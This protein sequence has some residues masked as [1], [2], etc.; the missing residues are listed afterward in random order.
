MSLVRTLSLSLGTFGIHI[1]KTSLSVQTSIPARL[2]GTAPPEAAA[3]APDQWQTRLRLRMPKYRPRHLLATNS[4]STYCNEVWTQSRNQRDLTMDMDVQA[5]PCFSPLLLLQYLA[6]SYCFLLVNLW[7]PN[8]P[9]YYSSFITVTLW[10][11]NLKCAMTSLTPHSTELFAVYDVFHLQVCSHTKAFQRLWMSA[12][13]LSFTYPNFNFCYVN[14]AAS[15]AVQLK[16]FHSLGLIQS[17][18]KFKWLDPSVLVAFGAEHGL[19]QLEEE[20]PLGHFP[21]FPQS[22]SS[23]SHLP[24]ATHHLGCCLMWFSTNEDLSDL[25]TLQS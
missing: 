12:L 18:H 5:V 6:L 24:P 9:L 19:P 21:L 4:W 17:N 16:L 22:C 25:Q 8:S 23:P 14:R 1:F 2:G 20:K 10:K 7:G 3:F 15:K 13:R 11:H